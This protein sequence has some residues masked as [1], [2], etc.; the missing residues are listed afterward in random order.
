MSKHKITF[1][2]DTHGKHDQIVTSKSLRKND[3]PLDLPGGDIL[4]HAGDF[5]NSG[6][7]EMEAI[8]FFKWFDEINN[9][10]TKI[11]IAGNHD[12]WAENNP[13]EFKGILT[14]YKTI[15]YLQDEECVLYYDGPNGD[16]PEENIRIYGSPWQPE[17]FDWAFNLP[18]HGEEMKAKWDAIP[19]NTDILVTHGPPF[20][21]L[22]IP[23]GQ[24]TLRVGCEMLRHR[25]DEIHPKI[26]VFGHIHGSAGYYFNGHTHFINAAVLDEQYR[27]MNM[28]LNIEWDNITN[29]IK[30]I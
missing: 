23:G 11:L 12:R 5:M 21:Y 4:I 10:D 19:D 29:E 2:S 15:E 3:Q 24:T 26:H 27:Y 20:G 9:Y 7:N 16:M 13:E 8:M 6:W 14:G 28:P 1:I 22:D 25:V 18:R 30:W 17:F